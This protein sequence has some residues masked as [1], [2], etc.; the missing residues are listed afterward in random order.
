MSLRTLKE[1]YIE[2]GTRV[3]MRA[4]LDVALKNGKILD[5]FRLKQMLPTIRLILQKGGHL[6]LIGHIDRPEGKPVLFLSLKKV[7][8]YFRRVLKRKVIFIKNPF[9]KKDFI[10]LNSSPDILLFENIRFW[11]GEEK[12][13]TNFAKKLAKWGDIYINESFANSHRKHASVV[14]LA[15]ILP[16]FA[17]IQLGKEISILDSVIKNPARPLVT[18]IG[19]AKLET[20]LPLIRNFLKIADKILLAGSI[21][22]EFLKKQ[23]Y[24]KN[25]KIVL[26]EDGLG[27]YGNF[28]DI[29]PKT[30]AHFAS[31]LQDAQTIIWNG[32]LGIA[33]ISRFAIGTKELA[34]IIV[35]SR[36]PKAFTVVGGGD[37]V[38]IL[39]KYKLLHGFNHVS[40]GGGAM[41]EFLAGNKLPALEVLKK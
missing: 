13:D 23:K 19:G 1:A 35:S 17:G 21:A 27:T 20:K 32:P 11:P 36:C 40:A 18:L 4:D 29:G 37:T 2:K 6:R 41:L 16:A 24:I 9:D 15:K 34:R 31:L 14:V 33:E 22:N 26:P 7:S 28:K 25:P 38:A 12:N 39:R 8:D 5:D 3:L 10:F 30:I